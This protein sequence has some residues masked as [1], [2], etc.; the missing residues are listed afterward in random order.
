MKRE[1]AIMVCATMLLVAGLLV[2]H[3]ACTNPFP[4]GYRT[5]LACTQMAQERDT[6]TAVW[7]FVTAAE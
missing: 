1:L 7:Q 3:G 2:L 5:T 4:I 6:I